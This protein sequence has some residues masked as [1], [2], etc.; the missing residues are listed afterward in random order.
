MS[1]TKKPRPAPALTWDAAIHALVGAQG[2]EAARAVALRT[3]LLLCL[4]AQVPDHESPLDL[5]PAQ[6]RAF[7]ASLPPALVPAGRETLAALSAL[8]PR[9]RARRGR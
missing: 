7:L 4:R 2:S 5:L 3:G 9:R 1:R 6:S 8:S